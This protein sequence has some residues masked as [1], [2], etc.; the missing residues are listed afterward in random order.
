MKF[1]NMLFKILIIFVLSFSVYNHCITQYVLGSENKMKS[2]NYVDG[3]FVN[4]V[5]TKTSFST[6]EYWDMSKAYI[7]GGQKHRTPSKPLPVMKPD[8]FTNHPS[9]EI[10]FVWLGHSSI[11]LEFEKKR[12]LIDPMFSERASGVQWFGPK[13][14]QPTPLKLSE[15]PKIDAVLISHN[16]Y[17]HLDKTTIKYLSG[18]VKYFYVPLG[19]KSILKN[20][21]I[22]ENKIVE[23]D[24]WEESTKSDIKIFATPARHFA[25]RGLFDMNETFWCSWTLIGEKIKVFFSGD[26]AE[27]PQHKEI[28][29]KFGP[30]DLAFIEIGSYDKLWPDV[31]SYPEDAVKA[32]IDLGG[33]LLVPIHW[34]TFDLA[35]HSWFE[36]I[37]RFAKEADLKKVNIIT[38][39]I[40]ETI[41]IHNFKNESWWAKVR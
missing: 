4:S 34:G 7:K 19:I 8:S 35:L 25:N 13:R 21:G 39:K 27:T 36:P 9:E 32:Y 22:D 10:K 29:E 20:W 40:G 17:D 15:L 24:W 16:H 38:P 6:G 31:H 12:F 26:T 18:K 33:K 14:F 28:G 41:D 11:L 2:E 3:K 5:P 37:E 23:L 30:F 1:L